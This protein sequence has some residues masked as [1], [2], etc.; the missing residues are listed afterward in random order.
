MP[1]PTPLPRSPSNYAA[2]NPVLL[3]PLTGVQC[4]LTRPIMEG[5]EES[6]ENTCP[7]QYQLIQRGIPDHM[8]VGGWDPQSRQ[9]QSCPSLAQIFQMKESALLVCRRAQART[10]A[11]RI[12]FNP[13]FAI[14]TCNQYKTTEILSPIP[15]LQSMTQHVS[16]LTCP[17]LASMADLP[18]DAFL[19]PASSTRSIPLCRISPQ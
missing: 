6:P 12:L 2:W 13:I 14:S 10:Q 3:G 17:L 18:Q 15:N 19:P 16:I 8:G 7:G 4:Q 9:W 11:S 5:Q 1:F